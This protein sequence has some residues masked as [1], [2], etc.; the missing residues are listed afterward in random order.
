[1]D[2]SL[3]P[4][5]HACLSGDLIVFLDLKRDRYFAAPGGAFELD[6]PA[7][8]LRACNEEARLWGAKLLE[9]A[10]VLES[11]AGVA[12][13]TPRFAATGLWPRRPAFAAA[14]LWARS[15]VSK[16]FALRRAL[17]ELSARRRHATHDI[18]RARA[19]AS[20]FASWRPLWPHPFKCLHDTLALAWFLSA[21]RAACDIVFGV[22]ARPFAAHCWAEIG[23]EILNDEAEY[24]ASFDVILRA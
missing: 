10:L 4:D 8:R 5:V 2:Y 21:R 16:P 24:C 22:Q 7:R 3:A 9:Q 19:E 23:G 1:M 15:A 17:A 11:A 6:I 12:T 14:L 18:P 13:P 20:L